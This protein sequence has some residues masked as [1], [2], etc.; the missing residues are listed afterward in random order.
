MKLPIGLLY[1][2]RLGVQQKLRRVAEARH[3]PRL[4][5]VED[6]VTARDRVQ[7]HADEAEGIG[8]FLR[9][10]LGR[11]AF[12]KAE[13]LKV[14]RRFNPFYRAFVVADAVRKVDPDGLMSLTRTP[15]YRWD[16]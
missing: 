4:E 13:L 9:F 3:D 12:L 7:A 8:H 10:G 6:Y 1:G 16:T 14:W 15:P 5:P 11:L 2:L